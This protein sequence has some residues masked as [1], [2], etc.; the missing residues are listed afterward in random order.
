[1]SLASLFFPFRL[2][3]EALTVVDEPEQPA[4]ARFTMG[5]GVMRS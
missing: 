2:G 4:H 1:M 3:R 5:H